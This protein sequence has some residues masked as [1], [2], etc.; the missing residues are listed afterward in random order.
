MKKIY[1]KKSL[2]VPSLSEGIQMLD[3][4]ENVAIY[5][6]IYQILHYTGR[7]CN[8][9]RIPGMSQSGSMT[10]YLTKNSAFTELLNYKY[11]EM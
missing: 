9:I 7:S 3:T 6:D 4:E 5:S 2:T 8:Y 1:K 10:L 11:V